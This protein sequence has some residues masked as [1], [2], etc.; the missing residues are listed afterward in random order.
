[1]AFGYMLLR[2]ALMSTQGITD[3]YAATTAYL[4]IILYVHNLHVLYPQVPM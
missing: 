1:M 4:M 3:E 2:H